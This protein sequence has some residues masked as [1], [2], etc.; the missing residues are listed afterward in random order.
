MKHLAFFLVAFSAMVGFSHA[1]EADGVLNLK[2]GDIKSVQ[3]NLEPGNPVRLNIYFKKAKLEEAQTL[4]SANLDK[5]ITILMEGKVVAKPR[6]KY[7]LQ[8]KNPFV[9]LRY[10]DIEA[11]AVA[12]RLLVPE[13]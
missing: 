1:Q 11:A 2:K 12:A 5:P 8:Y 9:T 7:P 4:I 3:I 6:I 13:Q 10:P